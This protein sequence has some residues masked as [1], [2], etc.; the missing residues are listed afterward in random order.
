MKAGKHMDKWQLSRPK[1]A[2]G[3]PAV[4]KT[5]TRILKP[6]NPPNSI[7]TGHQVSLGLGVKEER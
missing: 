5:E 7:R 2:E 1:T 6:E 4:G 3:K